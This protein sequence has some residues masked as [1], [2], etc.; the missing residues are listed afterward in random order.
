MQS[1][2]LGARLTLKAISLFKNEEVKAHIANFR[3]WYAMACIK[4]E[5]F[6]VHSIQSENTG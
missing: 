1:G 2:E 3:H 4:K 5:A 6:S